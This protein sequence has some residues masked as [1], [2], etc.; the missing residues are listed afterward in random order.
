MSQAGR[1]VLNTQHT[2]RPGDVQLGQPQRSG[3]DPAWLPLFILCIS[4]IDSALCK[5]GLVSSTN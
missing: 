4:L 3:S 5:I 1:T 2:A